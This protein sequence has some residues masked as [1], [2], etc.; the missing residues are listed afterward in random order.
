MA[1]VWHIWVRSTSR[2]SPARHV[3]NRAESGR[4]NSIGSYSFDTR[5]KQFYFW[6]KS[7]WKKFVLADCN[8][9]IRYC[10]TALDARVLDVHIR[11]GLHAVGLMYLTQSKGL[12]FVAP[13]ENR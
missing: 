13:N 2:Y 10:W 6:H 3:K 5:K 9:Y 7:K 11:T 1:H 12:F 8:T 4:T